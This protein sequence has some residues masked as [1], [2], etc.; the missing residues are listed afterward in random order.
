MIQPLTKYPSLGKSYVRCEQRDALRLYVKATE[1]TTRAQDLSKPADIWAKFSERYDTAQRLCDTTSVSIDGSSDCKVS[2]DCSDNSKDGKV[3]DTLIKLMDKYVHA[4]TE[5]FKEEEVTE[6]APSCI[7]GSCSSPQPY[8]YTFRSMPKSTLFVARSVPSTDG[9]EGAEIARLKATVE[10]AADPGNAGL[11]VFIKALFGAAGAI[12]A[13]GAAATIGG[14]A[15]EIGCG[16][17][18]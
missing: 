14:A 2:F 10:C 5:A 18:A 11:C 3:I 15:A 8:H 6:N 7:A 13:V 4:N 17:T 9:R 1:E 16:V 12:P